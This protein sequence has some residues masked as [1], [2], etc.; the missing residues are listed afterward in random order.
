MSREENCKCEDKEH[1]CCL[2]FREAWTPGSIYR[3]GD[4]VPNNGSSY[5]AI[6]WN[7]N[8]P[9]PSAN[10]ASIASKGDPG[11][12][13][14]AGPAGPQ[15]PP[16]IAGVVNAYA[17]HH[18]FEDALQQG[19]NL[20]SGGT[21]IASLSVP[22]GSYLVMGMAWLFNHDS[23]WQAW[24]LEMYQTDTL[25]AKLSGSIPGTGANAFVGADDVPGGGTV[26]G[27]CTMSAPG[28]LKLR[29]YG[30]SVY[31]QEIDFVAVPV[32]KIYWGS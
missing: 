16:G 21:D 4:A 2:H 8:D 19:T 23:D 27:V 13:G 29:G 3:P 18:S 26:M 30:Y 24:V 17:V 12:A 6:H 1:C 32:G 15:G 28:L 14:P 9:P 10:W 7:Q 20:G 11:P 5:V 22:A 25:F 31:T